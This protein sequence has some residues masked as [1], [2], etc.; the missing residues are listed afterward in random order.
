VTEHGGEDSVADD[1]GDDGKN[2]PLGL[3]IF[4]VEHF[5]GGERSPE[6]RSENGSQPRRTTGVPLRPTRRFDRSRTQSPPLLHDSPSVDDQAGEEPAD[7]RQEKEK[8]RSKRRVTYDLDQMFT[9]G[10]TVW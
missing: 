4:P 9:A 6:R 3:R 5:N 1:R 2:D 8:P 7:S 10:F